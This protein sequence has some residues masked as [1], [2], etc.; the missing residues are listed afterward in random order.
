MKVG[1]SQVVQDSGAKLGS[2]PVLLMGEFLLII[3]VLIVI[4]IDINY[5]C[6]SFFES[7][8][9]VMPEDKQL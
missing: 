2:P 3:S 5:C 4:D 6:F 7:L 8:G 1:G 9:Q